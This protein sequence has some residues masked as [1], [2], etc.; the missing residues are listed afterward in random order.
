MR[1]LLPDSFFRR[2]KMGYS[3]PL[4]VWFREELRDYVEDVLSPS[5]VAS[6]GVFRYDAVR[7]VLERHG[8][9]A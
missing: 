4:A 8:A 5:A 1:D 9:A 2:R 3:A 6:A 7:R